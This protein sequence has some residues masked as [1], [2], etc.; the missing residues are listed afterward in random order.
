MAILVTGAAGYIGAP[1]VIELVKKYPNTK[2]K[3]VDNFFRGSVSSFFSFPKDA[4]IEFFNLD[5][6]K[7]E[8]VQKLFK[9]EKVDLI[10]NMMAQPSAP[11]SD[12]EPDI[13]DDINT[14]AARYL[15][16]EAV[17]H[18][19][20]KVIHASTVGVYGDLHKEKVTEKDGF[21]GRTH[22]YWNKIC[23]EELLDMY[24]V[25]YGLSSISIR[26]AVVWG[27]S[28]PRNQEIEDKYAHQHSGLRCPVCK[29]CMMMRIGYC[30]NPFMGTVLNRF[31]YYAC[32]GQPITVFGSGNQQRGSLHIS[33]AVRAPMIA[34]EKID[35]K[36]THVAINTF[37]VQHSISDYADIVKKVVEETYGKDVKIIKLGISDERYKH[38]KQFRAESMQQMYTLQ[39]GKM[40]ELLGMTADNWVMLEDGIK[41]MAAAAMKYIKQQ[42]ALGKDVKAEDAKPAAVVESGDKK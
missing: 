42:E 20:K 28:M 34:A 22:Y 13:A 1:L 37:T 24:A 41:E 32:A 10:F 16:D 15:F 12:K 3:A 6:T 2:I 21:M 11:M 14:K 35:P 27:V 19:V 40:Q 30:N 33:D 26:Y 8:N 25:N 39:N 4:N 17:N 5:L 23:C 29:E 7:R 38:K 36:G 18:G 31:V 9:G